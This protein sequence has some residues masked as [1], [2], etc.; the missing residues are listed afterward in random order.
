MGEELLAEALL[1]TITDECKY[2]D[3][4]ESKISVEENFSSEFSKAVS[5]RDSEK[6]A[7]EEDEMEEPFIIKEE[8]P[9]SDDS[10]SSEENEDI[11]EKEKYKE[12]PPPSFPL[13]NPEET[14]HPLTEGT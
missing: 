6:G 1:S 10:I 14:A 2:D 12:Q 3:L 8:T 9:D 11:S 7:E 4:I 5:I 13:I